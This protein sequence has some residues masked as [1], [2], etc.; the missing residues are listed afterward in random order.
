M[1]SAGK[2][3]RD[4]HVYGGIALLSAGFAWWLHPG[5]G[6]AAAGLA[7]LGVVANLRR[8]RDGG[9]HVDS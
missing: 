4:L 9:T 1:K 3:L 6:L 2:T 7:L 8:L 5:A